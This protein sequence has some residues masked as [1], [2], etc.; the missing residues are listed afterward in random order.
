MIGN[1][2]QQVGQPLPEKNSKIYILDVRNYT[3]VYTYAPTST[4]TTTTRPSGPNNQSMKVVIGTICGIFGT[5]TLIAIGFFGYRYH[6]RRQRERQNI[7]RI[8]GNAL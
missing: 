6:Q 5:A 1:V 7:M 3:W 8:H 4:S 2:T